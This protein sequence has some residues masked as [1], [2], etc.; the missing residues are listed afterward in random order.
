MTLTGLPL[1]G[2]YRLFVR[3]ERDRTARRLLIGMVQ[4]WFRILV[5]ERERGGGRLFA[6]SARWLRRFG[7]HRAPRLRAALEIDP[8]DMGDMGRMQDFEDRAFAVEGHW[9]ARERS[10]AT[11][12]ETVCP[13][14]EIAS[15][16]PEICTELVHGLETATFRA[17]NPS[18]RLVPLSRLLS[19]GDVLCEFSHRIDP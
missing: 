1:R 10:S 14:A 11:R 8:T 2:A 18:Y 3:A 5:A 13:F 12:C 15:K 16:M 7:E 4:G 6:L 17:L 9:A 19:K